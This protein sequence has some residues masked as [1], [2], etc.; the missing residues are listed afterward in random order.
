MST[1]NIPASTLEKSGYPVPQGPKFINEA[2]ERELETY[3]VEVE[4]KFKK[5]YMNNSYQFPRKQQNQVCRTGPERSIE[6]D[7]IPSKIK[8]EMMLFTKEGRQR[9]LNE[10]KGTIT[11]E[12]INK[13]FD[14]SS[15]Q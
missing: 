7:I 2:V 12:A 13:T 3:K 1:N 6:R 8:N 11:N 9:L 10:L 14:K 4:D 15:A 5:S